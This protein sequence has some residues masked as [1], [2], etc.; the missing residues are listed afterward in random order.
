MCS[1]VI[2]INTRAMD[3]FFHGKSRSDRMLA[4]LV[5]VGG[6]SDLMSDKLKKFSPCLPMNTIKIELCQNSIV[7]KPPH[8]SKSIDSIFEI[9]THYR[10]L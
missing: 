3:R 4:G 9:F 10:R 2:K 8:I 7:M 6:L 5:N 1:C